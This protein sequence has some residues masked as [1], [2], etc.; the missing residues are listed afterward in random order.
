[1]LD[2][3][4]IVHCHDLGQYLHCYGKK[5]VQSPN[6]DAFAAE[7]VRFENHFCTAPQCSPSRASIFTGR[8][9]HCTGVLGL[10]Q[11]PLNWQMNEDERH[12]AQ[13]LGDV[14]YRTAA[15]GVTHESHTGGGP[16]RCGYQEH[17]RNARAKEASDKALGLI[18]EL[19]EGD[20]PFFL[21]VGYA[22]PHKLPYKN[23]DGWFPGENS[24]PGE[25]LDPDDELG[26]DI[27]PY[28]ADT[29]GARQEVAG[30]QGA[31]KHVDEQF[32]RIYSQ[33]KELGLLKNTVVAF[34]T[35]HGIAMPRSKCSL[36]D[37]GVNTALIMRAP[38]MAWRK[39]A[40]HEELISN[41]DLM[42]S[43]LQLLGVEVP[44]RIQGRSFVPLVDGGAYEKNEEIFTEMTY[45]TY[46]DPMRSIRTEKH[47][48]IA[49]FS[50]APR[51]ME[52]GQRRLPLSHPWYIPEEGHGGFHQ[53]VELFD[54]EKD[55]WE[56]EDLSGNEAYADIKKDLMRRLH[57]HMV[58]TND[59]LLKGAIPDP[60]YFT[61][62]NMLAQS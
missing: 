52:P 27:P 37:P 48:L 3:L 18:P 4:V 2:S 7:G 26:V 57:K 40:V 17:H 12:L 15:I 11:P 29:E 58:D 9:P 30:L 23:R 35:D 33:L 1:M 8:H 5:T 38:D 43:L 36:Y 16:K 32:G 42:P 10:T 41:I 46:Y 47:K 54:L 55:P 44:E 60:Q 39:G 24:W 61:T 56:K 14:G 45:H 53:D 62:L 49:F 25:H 19:A 21:S 59:P 13:I 22:E 31:V 6:L 20:R 28:L 51:F 50:T 34:T